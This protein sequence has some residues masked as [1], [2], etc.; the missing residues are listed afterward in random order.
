[1]IQ[2]FKTQFPAARLAIV[3]GLSSH[4]VEWIT[5]GRVDVALAYNP[6]A[7]AGLEIVPLHE[8]PLG[9][10]S[11]AVKARRARSN[12][13][14]SLP[15]KELPQYPLIVPERAH[16]MRRLLET[17]AALAGIRLDIA[18]EVSS[19]PSIID[20]VCAGFG[21]AVLTR[22]GVAASARA[23]ELT[24]RKLVEP[25][26]LSVLCLINSSHRRPTPL[27]QRTIG[28]LTT[29]VGELPV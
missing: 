4:I 9:L 21:H 16:A 19:I 11:R 24:V 27:V 1:L 7:Q 29:L 26:P 12:A 22:S 25:T 3:E 17:E 14:A 18:W 13:R 20:L 10:V 15:M 23:G 8:E 5:S 6:E 28:L 2:R